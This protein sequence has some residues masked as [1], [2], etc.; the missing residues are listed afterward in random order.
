VTAL[1][2]RQHPRGTRRQAD[3]TAYHSRVVFIDKFDEDD[4]PN[5]DDNHDDDSNDDDDD[6]D[7][8]G[9]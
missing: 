6:D 9:V 2:V 1:T 8:S 4:R 7:E 5:A 3:Q